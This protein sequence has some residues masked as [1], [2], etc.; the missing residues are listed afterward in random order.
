MVFSV[1]GRK[2]S[3]EE[4]DGHPPAE[5][6]ATENASATPSA[7]TED[8]PMPDAVSPSPQATAYISLPLATNSCLGVYSPEGQATT[9]LSSETQKA[10]PR[11]GRSL[12]PTRHSIDSEDLRCWFDALCPDNCDNIDSTQVVQLF[13]YMCGSS[14]QWCPSRDGKMEHFAIPEAMMPTMDFEGFEAQF[15]RY[16]CQRGLTIREGVCLLLTDSRCCIIATII[17]NFVMILI[18]VSTANFIVETVP[19]FREVP[20]ECVARGDFDCE[21]TSLPVFKYTE[22]VCI[23][24]FTAEYVL[25]LFTADTSCPACP[26]AGTDVMERKRVSPIRKTWKKM[27]EAMN[28]IDLLAIIPWYFGAIHNLIAGGSSLGGL[29]VLRIMRLARVFRVFKLGKYNEG[30][31]MFGAVLFKSVDAL[32]LLLFFIILGVVLFGSLIFTCERGDWYGP[33]AIC[34]PFDANQTCAEVGYPDG[35]YLRSDAAGLALEVTPFQTIPHSFWWVMVTVTTVGYGELYPTSIA[36]KFVGATTMLSGILILALPISIIGS[37]FEK[38]YKAVSQRKER[39]RLR[40]ETGKTRRQQ[41]QRS[42]T[43]TKDIPISSPAP[44]GPPNSS[45]AGAAAPAPAA[46]AEF[47]MDLERCIVEH[48]S[49]STTLL[50][51]VAQ[52]RAAASER[53][54]TG[55]QLDGF[56]MIALACFRDS[57]SPLELRTKILMFASQLS[58]QLS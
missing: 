26:D 48:C 58:T 37:H 35:V 45:T 49:R 24:V 3:P 17:A 2:F 55:E 19:A 53:R 12:F 27:T 5:G 10:R 40:E 11:L 57:T 52:I 54:L 14:G 15:N 13:S 4:P 31:Q 33:T 50:Q 38:E 16:A 36:G 1:L 8:N 43:A 28:L 44:R 47:D 22:T 23:L 39:Q 6:Q 20:A 42:S 30:M 9:N 29:A 21:R 25:R 34:W 18:L 51:E 32:L 56:L 46:T 41:R 7:V